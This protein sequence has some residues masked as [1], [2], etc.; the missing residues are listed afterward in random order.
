MQS[1]DVFYFQVLRKLN[2]IDDTNT[3][4]LKGR[5]ACEISNHELLITESLFHDAF[6]GL[7]PAEIAGILSCTVFEQKHC[8][9]PELSKSLKK[10]R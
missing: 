1:S 3:V 10:V 2:Y 8:S 4:T 6:S 5:V 7:Q 9:N